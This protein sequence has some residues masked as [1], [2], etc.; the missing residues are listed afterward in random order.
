MQKVLFTLD[1]LDGTALNTTLSI[2]TPVPS[3]HS[4][5]TLQTQQQIKMTFLSIRERQRVHQRSSVAP[6][7]MLL[8]ALVLSCILLL[9]QLP[10]P[11][12]EASLRSSLSLQ[13]TSRQLLQSPPQVDISNDF[14]S[15]QDTLEMARLS[16]LVYTFRGY[17]DCNATSENGEPLLPADLSCHLYH[18]DTKQGTQVMI[19]SSASYIAV[20]FAGTDDLRTMLTD[21][22]I[23]MKPFGP[24]DENGDSILLPGP[25]RVHA[26]FD[27]AVF[28]HGLF[29]TILEILKQLLLLHPTLFVTGHSL[30]A[31]DAI[32]TAVAL[33]LHLSDTRISCI[34]FGCPA[35]GNWY[36]RNFLNNISNDNLSIWRLVHGWDVVPRLPQYPFEHVG[37]TVQMNPDAL[38]AYYQHYGNQTLGYASVPYGWSGTDFDIVYCFCVYLLYICLTHT[39]TS[40]L[41]LSLYFNCS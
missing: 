14:P 38:H 25:A 4:S 28:S 17:T 27:N 7:V 6:I 32:L 20:V 35:T 37:H 2:S 24:L 21:T 29:D 26:G 1:T 36:W 5:A 41:S 40:I 13:S 15:L 30:G 19:L 18:H 33:S 9:V 31:A 11:T 3:T 22:D 10:S 12:Q 8:I 16:G 34:N 23:M 39:H